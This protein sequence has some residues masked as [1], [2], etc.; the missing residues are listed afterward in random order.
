MVVNMMINNRIIIDMM[1][2]WG[3]VLHR[4]VGSTKTR[5]PPT[6]HNCQP[7]TIQR[8]ETR[9]IVNQHFFGV[10]YYVHAGGFIKK[11]GKIERD[12]SPWQFSFS[13]CCHQASPSA[14]WQAAEG[15][16][17]K[18]SAENLGLLE[19]VVEAVD[20]LLLI[21]L[22]GLVEEEAVVEE[23][24]FLHEKMHTVPQVAVVVVLMEEE[25]EEHLHLAMMLFQLQSFH[26]HSVLALDA[27]KF[28]D[29][30]SPGRSNRGWC[31]P[32][33]SSSTPPPPPPPPTGRCEKTI[34]LFWHVAFEKSRPI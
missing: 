6:F 17:S 13:S 28:R 25:E 3:R 21:A 29:L 15:W 20:L 2:T 8:W 32:T 27:R 5:L 14:W 16:K 19:E 1:I 4:E 11:I 34:L 10:W 22:E 12:A 24:D 26:L 30:R 18:L 33:P 23:E 31:S 7:S 9:R